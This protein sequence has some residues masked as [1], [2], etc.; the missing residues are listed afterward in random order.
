[1]STPPSGTQGIGK[2]K[3]GDSQWGSGITPPPGPPVI[4]PLEPV[5]DESDVAQSTPIFI[6][7]TDDSLV[8]QATLRISV[9]AVTYVLGGVAQNGATMFTALN[10][11]NGIDVEL[12]LPVQFPLGSRQEVFVY[13][14]DDSDEASELVYH[15]NVGA[16]LR[17]LKVRNPQPNVLVAYFNRPLRQDGNLLF[18]PNWK[19]DLVSEGAA[20]L[21]I[22]EVMSNVNHPDYVTLRYVGGGSTY[23]LTALAA[24]DD[25]GNLVD[26][27]YNSAEFELVFGDA[28]DPTIQIFD[29]VYGPIG[30]RKQ[31]LLRRTM[32]GHVAIRS[33][34]LAVDEQIQ[35]RAG[36]FDSTVSRSGL[37]GGGKA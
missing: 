36:S 28:P 10:D 35:L 21:S 17:L 24:F 13:V 20:P 6:R 16:G 26:P 12:R 37:N 31:K 25:D 3:W 8:G 30:I 23:R 11:G 27:R 9:G 22:V 19:I 14:K 5:D 7:L 2:G 15:F 33:I 29:S 34:A 4:A 1:M 32:D 18:P